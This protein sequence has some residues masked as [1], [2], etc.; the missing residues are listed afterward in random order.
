MHAAGVACSRVFVLCKKLANLH[1]NVRS[2]R[3]CTF[4]ALKF[5]TL[6]VFGLLYLFTMKLRACVMFNVL[7]VQI[8]TGGASCV[9]VCR[10]KE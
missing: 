10:E 8:L 3:R 2:L 6:F 7:Y 1:Q 4:T 9:C 5:V